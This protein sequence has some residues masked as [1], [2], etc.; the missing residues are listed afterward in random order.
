[1]HL[2]ERALRGGELVPLAAQPVELASELIALARELADRGAE[3]RALGGAGA[4]L[5]ESR[6]TSSSRSA[7][8]RPPRPPCA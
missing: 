4:E 5:L 3:P 7:R 8:R 1:V 2:L 6:S